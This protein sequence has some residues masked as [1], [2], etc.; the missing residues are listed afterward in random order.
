MCLA[1]KIRI[2]NT[3]SMERA[4][5]FDILAPHKSEWVNEG[6][7]RDCRNDLAQ[8]LAWRLCVVSVWLLKAP[9]FQSVHDKEIGPCRS[10]HYCF[11]T[12]IVIP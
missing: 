11:E 6:C 4:A 8:D 7:D 2:Q 5:S 3:R 12:T 10:S 1:N 9:G